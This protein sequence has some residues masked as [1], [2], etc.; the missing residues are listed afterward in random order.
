MKLVLGLNQGFYTL[1]QFR[2][3]LWVDLDKEYMKLDIGKVVDHMTR[4]SCIPIDSVK[5]ENDY[6]SLFLKTGAYID[7]NKTN[8][9]YLVG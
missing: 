3:F 6:S 1:S 5:R 7:S 8:P 9:T 2:F 4:E